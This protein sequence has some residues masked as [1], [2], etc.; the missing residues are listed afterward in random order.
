MHLTYGLF[1]LEIGSIKY[2]IYCFYPI[3]KDLQVLRDT[4]FKKDVP[5]IILDLLTE[6][7]EELGL[8]SDLYLIT[9]TSPIEHM[10][11]NKFFLSKI[12]RWICCKELKLGM[13]YY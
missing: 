6:V 7:W 8:R 4:G 12:S 9:K 5:S 2:R 13:T 1:F 3:L 11:K 10:L